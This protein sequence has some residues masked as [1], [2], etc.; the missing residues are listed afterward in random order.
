MGA[1][2]EVFCSDSGERV[3]DTGTFSMGLG[4][5][6]IFHCSGE[7]NRGHKWR[8]SCLRENRLRDLFM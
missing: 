3:L 7:K 2:L 5:E 4:L 6:L 1:R 8:S